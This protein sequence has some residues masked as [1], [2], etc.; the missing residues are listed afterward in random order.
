MANKL[1]HYV[2][3]VNGI[4]HTVQMDANDA[5]AQGAVEVKARPVANK[6]ATVQNKG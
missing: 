6:A 1:K 5:E 3:K 4:E 2:I